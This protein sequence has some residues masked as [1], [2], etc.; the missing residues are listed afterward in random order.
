MSEL[1]NVVDVG[2]ATSTLGCKAPK[3]IKMTERERWL[4][5]AKLIS[6]DRSSARVAA[7]PGMGW[8]CRQGSGDAVDHRGTEQ[9][10]C[11]GEDGDQ[12]ALGT[13][14]LSPLCSGCGEMIRQCPS[15]CV[16]MHLFSN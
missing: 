11:G 16:Q 3:K 15:P 5:K 14:D 13:Q 2:G 4:P 7:R 10:C 12:P 1:V 9:R 6:S 8:G